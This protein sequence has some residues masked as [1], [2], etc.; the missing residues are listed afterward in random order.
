MKKGS[1][2]EGPF[3]VSL[4]RPERFCFATAQQGSSRSATDDPAGAIA[5]SLLS[6]DAAMSYRASRAV[7]ELPTFW[8]VGALGNIWSYIN[9]QLKWPALTLPVAENRLVLSHVGS[10]LR[11]CTRDTGLLSTPSRSWLRYEADAQRSG[12]A[13]AHSAF[14]CNRLLSRYSRRFMAGAARQPTAE[15][16][17]DTTCPMAPQLTVATGTSCGTGPCC[18]TPHSEGIRAG[19]FPPRDALHTRLCRASLVRSIVVCDRP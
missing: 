18:A 2:C 12:P 10:A 13:A 15:T 8:F 11:C 1:P 6:R 17:Q 14:R 16:L 3:S 7:V 9:Q 4:A 19:R 5:E